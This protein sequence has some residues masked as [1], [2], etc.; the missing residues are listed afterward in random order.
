[1]N[2]HVNGV[3]CNIKQSSSLADFLAASEFNVPQVV[4]A[5]VFTLM[6]LASPKSDTLI[7]AFSGFFEEYSRFSG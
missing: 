3:L 4:V 7:I 5:S 1:M 6:Y 2:I